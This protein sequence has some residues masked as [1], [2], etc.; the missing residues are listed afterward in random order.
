MN[1]NIWNSRAPTCI[2]QKAAQANDRAVRVVLQAE[3]K[4]WN[5]PSLG[6]R[7]CAKRNRETA[8]SSFRR[9]LILFESIIVAGVFFRFSLA[10]LFPNGL[11]I[12]W[13]PCAPVIH[14]HHAR[15][16]HTAVVSFFSSGGSGESFSTDFP[17]FIRDHA[18]R[19][20]VILPF[21]YLLSQCSLTHIFKPSVFSEL[22]S[23]SK[24]KFCHFEHWI[25]GRMNEWS[26]RILIT[27]LVGELHC[28]LTQTNQSIF[29]F[30]FCC[31]HRMAFASKLMINWFGIDFL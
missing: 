7:V 10:F 25:D 16:W 24:R 8:R 13:V 4:K 17:E 31:W 11:C 5:P 22:F 2:F 26:M 27:L 3:R 9:V 12:R 1:I 29:D 21:F 28:Y 23:F 14:Y 15:H 6:I 19:D 20:S 18:L 30:N